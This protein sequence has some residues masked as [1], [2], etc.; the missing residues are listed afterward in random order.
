VSPDL[1]LEWQATQTRER[2]AARAGVEKAERL[3]LEAQRQQLESL[4]DSLHKQNAVLM[5]ERQSVVTSLLQ[6]LETKQQKLTEAQSKMPSLPLQAS[7][8]AAQELAVARAM[9]LVAMTNNSSADLAAVQAEFQTAAAKVDQADEAI[10]AARAEEEAAKLAALDTATK[11]AL[12]EKAHKDAQL[13]KLAIERKQSELAAQKLAAEN[14]RLQAAAYASNNQFRQPR[15]KATRYRLA[16][17]SVV[18]VGIQNETRHKILI[19]FTSPWNHVWP[20]PGRAFVVEPGELTSFNLRGS[21][22]EPINFEAVAAENPNLQWRGC[23][24][25]PYGRPEPIAVCGQSDPPI[26]RLVEL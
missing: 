6:R 18:T 15:A 23:D 22:N 14:E 5:D 1:R 26:R 2:D 4:A 20:A 13:Q 16:E 11:T 3:A 24:C 21:A 7:S 17:D 25:G 8:D 19:T 10:Q 12:E 9:L